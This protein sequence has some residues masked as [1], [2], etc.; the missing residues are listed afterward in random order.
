VTAF[1]VPRVKGKGYPLQT[2]ASGNLV[3][4]Y[5][6]RH[7]RVK[8]SRVKGTL[9]LGRPPWPYTRANAATVPALHTPT[10]PSH[11]GWLTFLQHHIAAP[12]LDNCRRIWNTLPTGSPS[13]RA[14]RKKVAMATSYPL[15]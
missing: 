2:P 4:C 12:E 3:W 7:S 9:L 10:M 13:A 5:V 15:K 1:T 8:G 11:F 14:I 6:R